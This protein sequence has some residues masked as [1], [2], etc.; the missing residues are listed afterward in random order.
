MQELSCR[1]QQA[2]IV[3]VVAQ[4]CADQKFHR[5]VIDLLALLCTRLLDKCAAVILQKLAHGDAHGAID[6]L[7]RRHFKRTAEHPVAAFL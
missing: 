2:H 4:A 3:Q 6:L 7:F 5:H 1:L